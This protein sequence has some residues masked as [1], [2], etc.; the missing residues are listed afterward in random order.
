M[1][2]VVRYRML[3]YGL[4]KK[5]NLLHPPAVRTTRGGKICG[6][7][8]SQ[9]EGAQLPVDS[10]DVFRR[11]GPRLRALPC[12]CHHRRRDGAGS[13]VAMLGPRR[14]LKD[15]LETAVDG[16]GPRRTERRR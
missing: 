11:R 6:P 7:T 8:S 1:S 14:A 13:T 16:R 4:H 5:T 3:M 12:A 9:R 2:R 15:G 10:P